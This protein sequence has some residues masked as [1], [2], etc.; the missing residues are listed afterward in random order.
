MGAGQALG[1]EGKSLF[2]M[3]ACHNRVQFMSFPGPFQSMALILCNPRGSG[4]CPSTWVPVPDEEG[5]EAVVG[6]LFQSGPA[7]QVAAGVNKMNQQMEGFTLLSLP[8]K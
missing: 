1:M 3:L 6:F 7:A 8:F 4:D 5:L 2:D